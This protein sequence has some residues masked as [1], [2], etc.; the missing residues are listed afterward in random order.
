MSDARQL[1]P[2][3]PGAGEETP[4]LLLSCSH[5]PASGQSW[6]PASLPGVPT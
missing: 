6:A 2:L 4:P 1:Q 5:L 3:L